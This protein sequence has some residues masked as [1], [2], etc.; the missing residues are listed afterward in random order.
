MGPYTRTSRSLKLEALPADIK[1]AL[2]AHQDKYNLGPI[3]DDYLECVETVSTKR[4]KGLF[5][6]LG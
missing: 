2:Q 5:K 6:G 4:K 3:L 1:Q